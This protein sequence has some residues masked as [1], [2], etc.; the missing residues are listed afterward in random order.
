MVSRA[1]GLWEL[2][3]HRFRR[4]KHPL[5]V[6]GATEMSR[7]NIFSLNALAAD[8]EQVKELIEDGHYE[9]A[10]EFLQRA[11]I[12]HEQAG[13]ETLIGL[14]VAARQICLACSQSRTE[15][16]WHLRAQEEASER[17]GKLKD[18]LRALT[19]KLSGS[20]PDKHRTNSDDSGSDTGPDSGASNTISDNHTLWG[21]IRGLLGAS[22]NASAPPAQTK[23]AG[24]QKG[25][26]EKTIQTSSDISS[27]DGA[28]SGGRQSQPSLA[29]HCLGP[30]R[31]SRNDQ[32]IGAWSGSKGRSIFKYLVLRRHTPVSK[33]V[34]MDVFW[35]DA[36]VENA[37][38]NLHQAIY[39]LRQALRQLQPDLQVVL[40]ESDHYQINPDLNLW[41]D[42]EEFERRVKTGRRLESARKTAEAMAEYVRAEELY[43]GDFLEE[44]LYEDWTGLQREQIRAEYLDLADRLSA[45]YAQRG[46][47]A[48]AL[49]LCRKILKKDKCHEK[50]HRRLMHCYQAM[51]Q[52]SMAVRQY[53]LCVEALETELD[54]PPSAE[55]QML[56][57]NITGAAR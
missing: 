18:Q 43:R 53:Q 12:L 6:E 33:E 11:L 25:A 54:V 32:M 3:G 20:G 15:I 26:R 35:P 24:A 23:M 21:I 14:F 5:S 27:S 29:V 22:E 4:L 30:F 17:E 19:E 1:L 49:S 13:D 42:F 34:L 51:G 7:T 37:R 41:L 46:D 57:K 45:H 9:Q 47:H 36:D 28:S 38:R 8:W 39:S 48:A 10:A 55:T 31:V 40:F 56:F 44:D 2:N 52:T 50:A 16:I